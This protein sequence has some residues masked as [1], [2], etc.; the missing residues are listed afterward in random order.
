M[1]NR[2]RDIIYLFI[3]TI[4]VSA[5]LVYIF[6]VMEIYRALPC[7]LIPQ[8]FMAFCILIMRA[9]EKH[10]DKQNKKLKNVP[11]AEM[12]QQ[13]LENFERCSFRSISADN[14]ADDLKGI[15]RRRHAPLVLALAAVFLAVT[16]FIIW[17]F[18]TS[19]V[20]S[21]YHNFGILPFG[22]VIMS[23]FIT[24]ACIIIGADLL[25]GYPVTSFIE[26]EK[27]RLSMIERSYM[28]GRMI[29][30]WLSGI[31]VGIDY[32]VYYDLNTV[33]CF[34]T[35]DIWHIKV[36]RQITKKRDRSGFDVRDKKDISA[37]LSVRGCKDTFKVGMTELQLE[38][39]CDEFMRRGVK[40]VK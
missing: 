40:I 30:G 8:A 34:R 18:I 6:I 29:C 7:A 31:N 19:S 2:K 24:L 36:N 13:A 1:K 33:K 22:L 4:P 26:K 38:Y 27:D 23:A 15:L 25:I 21:V 16:F 3:C 14:M 17:L 10:I 20:S 37:E 5:I 11:E 39:I 9:Q 35:D 28:G 12:R 32:C